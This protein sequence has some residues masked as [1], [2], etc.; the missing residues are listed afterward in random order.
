MKNS[1]VKQDDKYAR[2]LECMHDGVIVIQEGII[3]EH[4]TCFEK[5]SGYSTLEISGAQ[6]DALL[7]QTEFPD[8]KTGFEC[9]KARGTALKIIDAS[10]RH[11]T[12]D[13]I[14]VKIQYLPVI[15]RGNTADLLVIRDISDQ[16]KMEKELHNAH[17]LESIAALSGGIAHD[18]NNLLTAILGNISMALEYTDPDDTVSDLL[19][20]SFEASLLAKELTKKLI[21][22]SKG[23]SPST[24]TAL[25]KPLLENTIE[26]TLSGSSVKYDFNIPTNIWP[27]EIDVSQIGQ[28]LHNIVINA[29]ESMPGGGTIEVTAE[30]S[31]IHEN[32]PD[33]KKGKYV[34]ISIIDHGTGIPEEHIANI[35]NPY[36]STKDMGAQ[37][38]MGLGLS[39]CLS[40]IKKHGGSVTFTSEYGTGSVFHVFLPASNKPVAEASTQQESASLR[41]IKGSGKILV[42][43]DEKTIREI[44][45]TMLNN[46]GYDVAFA[47]NGDEAV[48]AYIDANKSGRPFDAV[49]LDLTIRGGLG[50]TETI[51]KLIGIDPRVKG[52][53]SSGYSHDPVMADYKSFGFSGVVAK[54]YSIQELGHE[55]SEVLA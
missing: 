52:I 12:G 48:D 55:L 45:G 5:M 28:A 31:V 8:K 7:S 43:D 4:N 39:I 1:I 50:G 37:K 19:Q 46:L 2:L 26:F 10:L 30:N 47:N 42:M 23:G 9:L 53:V 3:E 41:N 20:A 27:V 44:A 34:K 29:R 13:R 14:D 36:F 33:L 51:K 6:F 22:F 35:F 11:K 24:E 54:P 25:I 16:I 18:Y 49:I 15:H 17:H 40:I 38:G 32:D 21:T